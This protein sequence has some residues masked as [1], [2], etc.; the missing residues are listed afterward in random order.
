MRYTAFLL[1][2]V[3]LF[4]AGAGAQV[5]SQSS[6]LLA[7]ADPG[8]PVTAALGSSPALALPSSRPAAQQPTVYGVFE[9]FN[10]QVSGGYTFIRFYVVP[11]VTADM[12]GINIGMVYYPK[13]KWIGGEG[14]FEGAWGSVGGCSCSKL[15]LATGGPRFRWAA[16]HAVELWAHGLVGMVHFL[17]QTAFGSQ[18]AFAYVVG[19]GADIGPKHS[20]IAYRVSADMIGTRL[21]S[22]YQYSP[23]ASISVVY[24]F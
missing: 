3:L 12:N 15:A 19:G 6:P 17:P 23:Q 21:F 7:S 24:K 14:E 11:G 1:G 13:G 20:K 16:P 10:W 18:T 5:N 22:T 2:V 8:T 4:A 9:N